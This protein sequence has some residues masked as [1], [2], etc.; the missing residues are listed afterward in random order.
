MS[1]GAGAGRAH[2]EC[3]RSPVW[4]APG[5][6]PL[7]GSAALGFAG[8]SLL[9]PV[10]PLWTQCGGA[11]E[12]GAGLVNTVLMLFTVVAQ[13]LVA[14]L[15]RRLGWAWTLALG[16]CLLGLPALGH[17]LSD[18]VGVVVAL[19]AVR[20]LG[21]GILTVCGA[22]GVAALVEPERRG[23]AVGA[24]GLAVAVPQCLLVPIAPW[25]AERVGFGLVFACAAVPLLAVPLAPRVAHALRGAEDPGAAPAEGRDAGRLRRVLV[26]PIAALLAITAAGGAILTF[27]PSLL[28]D[29]TA[30]YVALL[31]FTATAALCRWRFG[32]VADRKGA[33]PAIAPLLLAGA[34]GLAVIGAGTAR[35]LGAGGPVLVVAGMLVVGVAYGGLQNLTLV[36]AFAAAGEPARSSVSVAWNIGFDAGTGLGALAAGALATASSYTVAYAV[37]AATTAFVGVC[38][39]GARW[40][41]EP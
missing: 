40:G 14:R 12:L 16:A 18:R 6:G 25:L 10:A 11:D 38:W 24:Y 3:V 20:G 27:T 17:F 7:L 13:L 21:F 22:T 41:N 34:A 30:V 31:A 33:A 1:N 36:H 9:L 4:R 29:A 28:S 23:R 15:L 26:G 32:H 39:A 35:G 5:M 19:A 8:L 2:Q 37:L